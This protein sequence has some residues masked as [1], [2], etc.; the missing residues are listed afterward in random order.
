[1][2][3]KRI[4]PTRLS[5]LLAKLLIVKFVGVVH[6]QPIHVPGIFV[7]VASELRCLS[8][9]YSVVASIEVLGKITILAGVV[10]SDMYVRLS[11]FQYSGPHCVKSTFL[12]CFRHA[13]HYSLQVY[14]SYKF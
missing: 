8:H 13:M 11:H 1:L 14:T 4:V 10:E 3:R 9:V 2:E 6:A 12:F 5:I 7:L